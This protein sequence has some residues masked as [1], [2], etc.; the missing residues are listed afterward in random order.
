MPEEISVKVTADTTQFLEALDLAIVKV[1]ELE[2]ACVD[3][4]VKMKAME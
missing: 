3:C 2:Q 1:R 4:A